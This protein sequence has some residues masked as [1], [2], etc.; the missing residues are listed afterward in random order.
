MEN[1]LRNEGR[2]S[3]A[4]QLSKST[5]DLSLEEIDSLINAS[6]PLTQVYLTRLRQL[7]EEINEITR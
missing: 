2:L 7:V 1:E 4:R 3:L 6:D 5:A